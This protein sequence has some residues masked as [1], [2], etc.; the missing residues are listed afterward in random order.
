LYLENLAGIDAHGPVVSGDFKA[1]E[2]VQAA[3]HEDRAQ[4]GG[5]VSIQAA[6]LSPGRELAGRLLMKLAA[7]DRA[8][9]VVAADESGL[10]GAPAGLPLSIDVVDD[11]EAD[12]GGSGGRRQGR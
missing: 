2:A 8:Q 11:W 9:L 12:A 4:G 7:R 10:A 3:P 5:R 6:C 1:H